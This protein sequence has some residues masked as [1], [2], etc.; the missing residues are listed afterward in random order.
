MLSHL[1]LLMCSYAHVASRHGTTKQN[2][3]C[4]LILR[5]V[6]VGMVMIHDTV[7]K[8]P[9]TRQASALV[10]D[11]RQKNV[12]CRGGIPDKLILSAVK[13]IRSSGSFELNLKA[14]VPNHGL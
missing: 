5:V 6:G 13:P 11:S 2:K 9:G 7:K 3:S 10:A 8:A 4:L 1:P 14:S 12:V